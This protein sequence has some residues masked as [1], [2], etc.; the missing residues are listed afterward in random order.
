MNSR[1]KRRYTDRRIQ[2]RL[3]VGLIAM[4]TSLTCAAVCWLH[5]RLEQVLERNLYRIHAASGDALVS[6]FLV[7]LGFAV[8]MMLTASCVLLLLAHLIWARYVRSVLGC[9]RVELHRLRK[10][11]LRAASPAGVVHHDTLDLLERWRRLEH[12]RFTSVRSRVAMICASAAETE[13]NRQ[14]I[15]AALHEIRGALQAAN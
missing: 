14:A 1:R 15:R 9:F 12:Q 2:G 3:L 4:E 11:D 7:E 8:G 10:L 6:S 13:P 5:L